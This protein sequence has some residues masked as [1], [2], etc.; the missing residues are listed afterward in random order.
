MPTADELPIDTSASALDMANEIFG[1]G[2]TVTGATYSGDP[3]SSGTYSDGIATS[4]GV[5]PGDTG[6]ILST[7]LA[8]DF[9][10]SDGSLDTNTAGNTTT[11]TSGIDNDAD[12]NALAG[13]NTFDASILEV[14]FIPTGDF[15]T[16]DFVIAS[17]EY[18]EW[19]N[20][21]FL[22]VVGVWV[23]GVQATVSIGNGSASVGNINA[24][25]APNLYNDNTS[26]QFNTEMDGFTITLTFVAPVNTG[27][28]NTLRIGV[29]DVSD[30]NYDT[31]LLVAGGSVQST[32]V[33]Q[34]DSVTL[35]NNDTQIVDVLANDLSSGGTLS[36]TQI[37][38]TPVTNPG[39][40]VTL[41]TGQTVTLNADGTLTVEGDSDNETVYFTYT[42]QDASGNSDTAIVEVEQV[43]CFAAGTRIETAR[44]PIAVERLRIG[45]QVRTLDCGYMPILW[46]GSSQSATTEANRPVLIRAGRFGTVEDVVVSAN[47]A[48]LIRQ[49][50]AQM[51][52][53]DSEVLVRAKHLVDG[54]SVLWQPHVHHVTYYHV[55]LD[56]HQIIEAHG[57]LS[58]SFLPGKLTMPHI[59]AVNRAHIFR[60]FPNLAKDPESYGPTARLVLK[61]YETLPLLERAA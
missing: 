56:S 22:D 59:H 5:V 6:V 40:S 26:D 50:R 47:H 21:T 44:G 13:T 45:D 31:N 39:D 46:I 38:G 14:D 27:V 34:D 24:S 8:T 58:E 11:N 2:V 17:E 42:A 51:L 53:E 60:H 55:L 48:V 37:N 7:G 18:P 57:L 15:V 20:S 28:T 25:T 23:N 49:S 32:I 35:G 54:R 4:N 29:A 61:A 52:F 10:N 12:F 1:S 19:I 16:V 33:T 9:T 3:L 36:V 30:S 43:P 41:G